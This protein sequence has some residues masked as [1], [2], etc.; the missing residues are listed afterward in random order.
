MRVFL[1]GLSGL[2]GETSVRLLK[3][4]HERSVGRRVT[5]G[6]IVSES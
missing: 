5:H 2:V 3:E 6:K 1:T 4:L